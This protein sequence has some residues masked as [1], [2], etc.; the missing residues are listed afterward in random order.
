VTRP[1]I[2]NRLPAFVEDVQRKAARAMTAALVLGASEAAAMTP[3][4]TS[5]LINSQ[6]KDVDTSNPA[7][8]V[9]TVLYTAEYALA[10]HEAP[11]KL[12]GL[13]VPRPNG[14]GVV[15]GPSGEPSFLS[16]GFIRAE[17]NIRKVIKGAIKV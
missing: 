9:G 15:W 2:V 6:D 4:A 16:K 5:N 7:R 14:L 3:R 13:N 10:V 8:I 12:R 1:R 11:G 17:P